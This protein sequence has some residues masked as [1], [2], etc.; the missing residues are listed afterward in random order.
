MKHEHALEKLVADL[1]AEVSRLSARLSAVENQ[2]ATPVATTPA[3]A[4]TDEEMLAISAAIA[5]FLGVR[6]QIRQV[7]LIHTDAWAQ[8]GRVNI[9]AS[10]SA[11]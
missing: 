4:I 3:E 8:V 10:H 5:A 1:Q 2:L 7:R 6:A 11:H 9:Q